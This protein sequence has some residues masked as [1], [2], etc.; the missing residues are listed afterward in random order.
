MLAPTAD[1]TD[2][3]LLIDRWEDGDILRHH[4]FKASLED[5]TR[6]LDVSSD[7]YGPCVWELAVQGH[8]RQ[9]WIADVLAN[10]SGPNIV[11]YLQKGLNAEL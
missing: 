1:A 2:R 11:S 4:H 9:A 10:K 5:P 8:E 3:R 7:H 6:F